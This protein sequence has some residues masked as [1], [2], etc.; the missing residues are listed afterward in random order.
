MH[1]FLERQFQPSQYASLWDAYATI[2]T[3]EVL[4]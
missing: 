3:R 2:E 1:L 4:H